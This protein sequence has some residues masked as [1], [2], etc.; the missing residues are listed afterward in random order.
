MPRQPAWL[1]T[2]ANLSLL[3]T[4]HVLHQN[5]Y[6]LTQEPIIQSFWWISLQCGLHALIFILSFVSDILWGLSWFLFH[7]SQCNFCFILHREIS[8]LLNLSCRQRITVIFIC[9]MIWGFLGN[10]LLLYLWFSGRT[11][12][13]YVH[14]IRE[15]K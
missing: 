10:H 8:F 6:S 12:V 2:V 5:Q 1:F 11:A 13:C 14:K 15:K 7:F 3:S 9:R 4:Q